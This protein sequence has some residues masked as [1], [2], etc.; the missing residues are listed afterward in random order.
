MI[1]QEL[2]SCKVG[3][4]A[5]NDDDD[6][7]FDAISTDGPPVS[8]LTTK[9]Y[10]ISAAQTTPDNNVQN[11]QVQFQNFGHVA[12]IVNKFKGCNLNHENPP[13]NVCS[14]HKTE[15]PEPEVTDRS[16]GETSPKNTGSPDDDISQQTTSPVFVVADSNDKADVYSFA[17]PFDEDKPSE[18][19]DPSISEKTVEISNVDKYGYS[20]AVKDAKGIDKFQSSPQSHET[21]SAS[22][23]SGTDSINSEAG[24]LVEHCDENLYDTVEPTSG[25]FEIVTHDQINGSY[26]GVHGADGSNQPGCSK[27]GQKEMMRKLAEGISHEWKRKEAKKRSRALKRPPKE[28]NVHYLFNQVFKCFVTLVNLHNEIEWAYMI[29]LYKLNYPNNKIFMQ[30]IFFFVL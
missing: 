30:L 17:K 29:W 11:D 7:Y 23:Y 27:T 18:N 3:M 13:E 15:K 4:M 24:Q 25:G 20:H 26:F 2:L 12:D 22:A 6:V 5:Y 16:P 8:K 10:T 28:G 21:V 1:I 14:D 9:E 19:V